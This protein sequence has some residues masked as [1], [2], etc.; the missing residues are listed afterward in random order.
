MIFL[1]IFLNSFKLLN[2]N[3]IFYK[4]LLKKFLIALWLKIDKL[5]SNACLS[6]ALNI[7]RLRRMMY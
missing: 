7:L 2:L 3:K 4:A 1:F 6:L 5:G